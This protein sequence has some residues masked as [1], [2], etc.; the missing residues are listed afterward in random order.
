M[1]R[2]WEGAEQ[3]QARSGAGAEQKLGR[4]RSRGDAEAREEQEQG[5]SRCMEGAR[6]EYG[7]SILLYFLAN[8][9]P[10]SRSRA[11]V[12]AWQEH[13]RSR[14]GAGQEQRQEQGKKRAGAGAGAG[15]EPNISPHTRFHPNWVIKT[16]DFI[17]GRF[18][19][20]GLFGN[21]IS[22]A[23]LILCCFWSNISPHAKLRQNHMENTY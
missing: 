18:W 22:L 16:E 13:G 5:R 23:I 15:Q 19:L 12:G 10:K 14:A 1:S 8:I 6:Q 2:R 17:I 4:S 11:R 20:V 3:K 7:R 21:K 9:S